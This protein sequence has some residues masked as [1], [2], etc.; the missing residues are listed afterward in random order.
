MWSLWE[1][2]NGQFSGV[3]KMRK[4]G[5]WQMCKNRVTARLAMHFV[6]LKCKGIMEGTVDLIKKLCNKLE[7]VNWF[8]YMGNTLNSSGDCE[9]A[10]TARVR[11]SWVK[12]S[13]CGELLLKNRFSL[14]IKG[15]VYHCCIISAILYGSKAWCLK[16]NEK[17]ILR[18]MERAMVRAMCGQKVADK[19]RRLKN[20]WTCGG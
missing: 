11:I 16:E 13:K 14:R 2:S 19:K 5:S 15:K 18:K 12:F 10:V 4:L 1:E 17:V 3:H 6:C 20:R 9:A 8:G 7:T